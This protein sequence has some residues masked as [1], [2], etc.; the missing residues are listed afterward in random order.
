MKTM[1]IST[2]LS[3]ILLSGL[4]LAAQ[5]RETPPITLDK[6]SDH[7]YQILGGSGSNG[8]VI[9]GEN[10]ALVIDAKMNEESVKQTIEA[11]Q[12]V[13]DKPIEY[14]VNTHSDGDHIMGN[15][16]FPV[17]V[18]FIAHENCRDDFFKENFGRASDWGEPQFY[19]FTPSITF[20][21]K[22][23][24]WLGKDLVELYYF[25]VGHTTGD[26]VVCFPEDQIAF[27][28]DQYF[29]T[30]PQLI[31]AHKNG[32]SFEHVKTLGKMLETLDAEIFLSGH[33]DPVGREDIQKHIQ[34]MVE[35]QAKVKKLIGE[36]KSKE[37]T[38]QQFDENEARLVTAIYD[39]IKAQKPS[40]STSDPY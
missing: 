18:T 22:L 10:A 40:Q 1:K 13:T 6:Q 39:E 38:L 12:A 17:S 3:I 25:G 19:P 21:E 24:I 15:R 33:S 34:S 9:I 7:V 4:S 20:K 32:N 16:F 30:R 8:G 2:S 26:I 27:I 37:D 31:H 35:R 5:E 28:G 36:G 29:N 11:I 14:L 23:N